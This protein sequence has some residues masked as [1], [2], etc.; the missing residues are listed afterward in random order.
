MN[1]II[2]VSGKLY[3]YYIQVKKTN[4][5]SLFLLYIKELLEDKIGR[6]GNYSVRLRWIIEK[7][8]A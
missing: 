5:A 1:A 6:I 7:K 4:T 2:D 8:K 3:R